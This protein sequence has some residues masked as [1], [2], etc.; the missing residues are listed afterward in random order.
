MSGKILN[1]HGQPGNINMI[2]GSRTAG[3][4]KTVTADGLLFTQQ[5]GIYVVGRMKR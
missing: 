1:K 3:R 2:V 5:D 4:K